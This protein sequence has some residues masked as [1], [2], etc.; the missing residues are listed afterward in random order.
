MSVMQAVID[1]HVSVPSAIKPSGPN[2]QIIAAMRRGELLPIV[3][4]AVFAEDE[5]MM[6][7]PRFGFR[8]EDIHVVLDMVEAPMLEPLPISLAGLPDPKDVPFIALARYA[9][10][11]VITGNAKHFPAKTG[12]VVLTPAGCVA[13]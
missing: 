2:G 7:R 4:H 13:E 6:S 10:C 9:G 12:V 1:T 8:R 3:S 11:P 5:Q